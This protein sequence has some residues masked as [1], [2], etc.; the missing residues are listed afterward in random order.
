MRPAP[1]NRAQNADT[2][3]AKEGAEGVSEMQGETERHSSCHRRD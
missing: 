1:A 2:H 3:P